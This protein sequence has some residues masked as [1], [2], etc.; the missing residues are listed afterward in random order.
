MSN[1][2]FIKE[3]PKINFDYV[4]ICA[5]QTNQDF[6][7]KNPELS[8]LINVKRTLDLVKFYHSLGSF[9]IFPSTSLVFNGKKQFPEIIDGK[10]PISNY[11]EQKS[12]VEDELLNYS[13]KKISILRLTKIIG[14]NYLLFSDWI[15]QLKNK[16][17]IHPFNDM[18]FSP[19]SISFAVECISKI[20]SMN[21]SGLIHI[22]AN[23]D[24]SYSDASIFIAKKLNLDWELIEPKSYLE[25][26]K[27]IFAT[28]FSALGTKSLSNIDMLS[29]TPNSSL[30]EFV[31]K[32]FSMDFIRKS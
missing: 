24:I 11:A 31:G 9:I 2:D 13:S 5:A 10:S 6:C 29:P 23:D 7:Q 21:K 25:I 22:S 20:I 18:F 30:V 27:N 17:K 15:K 3:L 4:V 1:A 8:Y 12:I 32:K 19:I 14:D 26:D 16:N 28:K